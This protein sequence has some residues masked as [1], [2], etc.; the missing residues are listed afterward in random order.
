VL[1]GHR[2]QPSNRLVAI[3]A[4]VVAADAKTVALQVGDGDGEGLGPSFGQQPPGLRATASGQQRHALRR[5]EAV[6]ERLHP[7]I[8]PL[9]PMLPSRG[10]CFAVQLVGVQAQDLAAQPLDRLDLD[11]PGAAQPAGRLHRAHVTLERLRPGQLLQVLNAPLGRAGLEGLQQ[12]R[13]G[14]LGPRVGPP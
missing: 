10:K 7:R 9:A 1:E 2:R 4:V 11:P 12:R 13:R 8:H 6:V 3:G 14:Q 5:A